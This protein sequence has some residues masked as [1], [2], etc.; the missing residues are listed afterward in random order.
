MLDFQ[1]GDAGLR[2]DSTAATVVFDGTGHAI[3]DQD[4]SDPSVFDAQRVGHNIVFT[5]NADL[6]QVIV[7][8]ADWIHI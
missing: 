2:I 7:R 3:I 1:R 6:D 4:F 5:T 8:N